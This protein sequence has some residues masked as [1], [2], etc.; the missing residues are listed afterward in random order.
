MVTLLFLQLLLGWSDRDAV[1]NALFDD[2]AKF[3]LGLSRTPEIT[4]DHSTLGKFR[5]KALDR[6]VG[7]TLLRDTLTEASDAGLLGDAGDLIDSF[8]VAGAAARHGTLI[9]IARAIRQVLVEAEDANWE[10]PTL[11]RSDYRTGRKPAIVWADADA[12]QALLQDLVADAE[13]LGTWIATLE[14]PA[15]SLTQ[16]GKLLATVATQDV[17]R[18]DDGTVQIAQQVAPDR[19][20]STVD[21]E[22][23]HGRKSSSQ[24]FDGYKAHVTV[25]QPSGDKPR[26]ITGMTVTPG[27][28]PDGDQTVAALEERR[29]LTGQVPQVLMGDTAYGG[30]TVRTAVAEAMPDVRLEAPVP[31]ASARSGLFAK[32]DCTMDL[33][34]RTITCPG[35]QTVAIPPRRAST[36]PD[37]PQIVAFPRALCEQCPLRSHCVSGAG[38]RTIR[39]HPEEALLQ[40]ERARQ[41]DPAWQARYRD[42]TVVEH[43][44]RGVTRPRDRVSHYWGRKKTEMQLLWQAIGYNIRELGRFRPTPRPGSA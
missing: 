44:I 34:A 41:A 10:P 30:A 32:T 42:R 21:P 16:A 36:A 3:A 38:P 24:K 40:T 4:G 20:L 5:A 19:V 1:E 8:M 6:E 7:R 9:V 23:R 26:L 12:R 43:V 37:R 39:I 35:D 18:T 29:Q 22:M 14:A 27:N 17:V 33:R 31:P 25:Q 15:E 13:T 28:V 11:R 2:R